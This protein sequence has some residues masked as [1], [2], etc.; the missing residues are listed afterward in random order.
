MKIG[1]RLG[2]IKGAAGSA[3]VELNDTKVFAAV[4]GPMEPENQ[5]QDSALTGIVD[6]VIE[7]AWEASKEFD[8]LC[9]KLLHTFSSTIFHKKYFKTLIRISITILEKGESLQDA[10]TLAGSLALIDAGIEMKDFVVSCTCGF[11]DSEF[12]PFTSS[13]CS[14]R[15]AILPST[16]EIVETE[17]LGKV[18][19]DD[20]KAAVHIATDGCLNLIESIRGYFHHRAT[21]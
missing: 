18:S 1:V 6:C 15:V 21:N 11:V 7:N 14:V 13:N 19:P 20:M 4:Y 16:N 12:Q 8:A 9:H 5:Q 17:V 2:D 3:Y 10:T